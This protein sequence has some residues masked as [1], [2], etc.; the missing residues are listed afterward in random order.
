MAMWMSQGAGREGG[1]FSKAPGAFE[2]LMLGQALAKLGRKRKICT[3][4]NIQIRITS[5]LEVSA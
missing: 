1:N 2:E 3:I 4:Y 5:S